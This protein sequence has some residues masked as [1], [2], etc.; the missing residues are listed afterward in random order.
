MKNE[1]TKGQHQGMNGIT[2]RTV[3]V[4]QQEPLATANKRKRLERRWK[5]EREY[6]LKGIFI[7]ESRRSK[8]GGGGVVLNIV[9]FK[10]KKE[11]SPSGSYQKE[12]SHSKKKKLS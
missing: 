12:L 6:C 10:K 11:N 5:E 8:Y 4:H 2:V 1:T 9:S 3:R 7:G